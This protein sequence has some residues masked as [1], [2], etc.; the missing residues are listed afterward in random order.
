[1]KISFESMGMGGRGEERAGT[2]TRPYR[3]VRRAHHLP[4]W[5]TSS[6]GR[7]PDLLGVLWA[8]VSAG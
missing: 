8:A 1:M 2:G 4:Q 7:L 6:N 5:V 3:I